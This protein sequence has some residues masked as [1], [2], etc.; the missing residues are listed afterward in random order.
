MRAQIALVLI[1]AIAPLR[2]VSAQDA[3]GWVGKRVLLQFGSVLRVGN[4]VVDNQKLTANARGGLRKLDRI[5]RVEQVNGPWLWLQAEG[6]GIAGW[7][8]AAEVIPFDQAIDYF[9]NQIRANPAN[10]AAYISRG[11]IWRDRQEF[12]LALADFN[13]ALRLDPGSE[14]CWCNRGNAW[15]DK[16]EYDKAIADYTEAIRLDPKDALAYYNRGIAWY[17]KKDYDKALADYNEAIRLDPKDALAYYN[18][19]IA[20]YAKKDY[21]KALADYNE[22]I[23]LDPKDATAYNNR[24]SAWSDKKEYD[25]AI[26]DYNE[27][28]RL[29]PK[30]ATAYNNRGI[31]WSDKK[32]YDKALADYTE[33]IRLD[34]QYA[35]AHFSR[36][37]TCLVNRQAGAIDG[38][39]RVLELESGN[40]DLSTFSVIVGSLAA[41]MGKDESS[42]KELLGPLAA[43]LDTGKWPYPIVRYLRAE[44]DESTLLALA[45]D[46][47]KRTE[48]HCYLGLDRLAQGQPDRAVVHFHW[49]KEHG[50][51]SY[52]EYAI[53]I[54]ELD[55]AATTPAAPTARKSARPARTTPARKSARP[56]R[57]TP[58]PVINTDGQADSAKLYGTILYVPTADIEARFGA[59]PEPLASYIIALR[60]R[61]NAIMAQAEPTS[62]KGLLVAVGIKE[63]RR[64]KVW[65]QVIE[66]ELPTPLLRTLERELSDVESVALKQGPAAV[67]L[68]FALNGKTPAAFPAAPD[69]WTDAAQSTRSKKI[70]PPDDLF[71]IIWPD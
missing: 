54:A 45:T 65:C 14:V 20:W 34:P 26:A 16:K 61:T 57:T 31:A 10:D 38:A 7:V 12:D 29:D 4:D 15:S 50:N 56:A 11:H 48:A 32:E 5:Y 44:L 64:T 35:R 62:A 3:A 53:A 18:R 59:N 33:A 19:G 71:K 6:V 17:A 39:K 68:K 42:A 23:R 27:A 2:G 40:G 51:T 30:D 69:R 21:D 1:L 37:L 66:G 49:V 22:A 28:I 47:D 67:G 36:A 55:R 9:T 63:G 13:E 60:K 25:K 58:A 43:K 8:P 70:I 46:D 52:T 24:G 41:R